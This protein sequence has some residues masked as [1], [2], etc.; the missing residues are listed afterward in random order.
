[1]QPYV[2]YVC[3][4]LHKLRKEFERSKA[5]LPPAVGDDGADDALFSHIDDSVGDGGGAFG[6]MSCRDVRHIGGSLVTFFEAI[7]ALYFTCEFFRVP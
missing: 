2:T 1:M 6:I 4:C 3:C 5:L 7:R